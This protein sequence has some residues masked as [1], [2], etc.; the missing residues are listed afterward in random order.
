MKIMPVACH[1]SDYDTD[2]VLVGVGETC[3]E[4]KTPT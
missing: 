4:T 1:I 3:A 2:E